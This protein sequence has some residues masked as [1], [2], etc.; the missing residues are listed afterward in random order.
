M[1]SLIGLVLFLAALFTVGFLSMKHYVKPEP[2]PTTETVY[3]RDA[4]GTRHAYYKGIHYVKFSNS[5]K[6][7]NFTADS[8]YASI[9]M[10]EEIED[11]YPFDHSHIDSVSK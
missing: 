8:T 11:S 3:V 2:Q 10:Q 1:K 4:D 9:N 7:V 6:Y 5:D